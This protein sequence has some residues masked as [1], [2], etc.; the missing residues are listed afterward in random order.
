MMGPAGWPHRRL[1]PSSS[2]AQ[3]C[4][5]L[6]QQEAVSVQFCSSGLPLPG[7]TG[8]CLRPVLQLRAATFWPNRRLSPSSSAAQ[9]CHF[10][11]PQEAV[12]VQFCSSGLPLPGPTGGCLRPVL[13]L[14]AATLLATSLSKIH[15]E[16]KK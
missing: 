8:G 6:A 2:A 12:A 11:A 10:L 16:L 9:G 4:H 7:P 14:R 3:G 5:F 1:S 15:T 13:Q